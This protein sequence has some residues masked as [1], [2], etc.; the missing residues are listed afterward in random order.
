[1]R[2]TMTRPLFDWDAIEDSPSI[3]TLRLLLEAVPD[4]KLLRSL[5]DARGRGRDDYPVHVLWG[6]I[7]LTASLRHPSIQ[8]C[9]DELA[10]NAALRT[11][12]GIESE[13]GVPKKW[14]VSRF[15]RVLGREP[16]LTLLRETFNAM[17]N[18][19]AECVPEFG[20]RTAGDA[21]GLSARRSREK[22]PK[23]PKNSDADQRLPPPSG[24][25]KEYSDDEGRVTKIV[26]W[27]GYKLHL[28]VDVKHEVALAYQVTSTKDGDGETLP[29]LVEQA[30]AN[31]PPKRIQTLAYDKAADSNDV[32]KTLARADIKPLI[33]SRSLWKGE[34]ERTL[35]GHDGNSNVVYDETGTVYCYDRVSDPVV[36]HKMA[37]IGLEKSRGTLK[38]RCPAAHEGWRCR[39]E[40][41][42]N[43]GK[44]YGKT[45]RVK[46]E[47]DF[48]R[49]PPI[50]RA[51]KKFQRLYK[52]RTAVE[53]VN[54]RLKLFWG[55]DD[56]N[57]SGAERFFAFVGGVMIVHLAFATLLASQPRIDT[58]GKMRLSPIAERIQ[59]RLRA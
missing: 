44:P 22:T 6:V 36:R 31:L 8:A 12:I 20:K 5:D 57:I 58:L 7:L 2:V 3:R 50:P 56:G 25:R 49:F 9:L 19:L 23:V 42:C 41:R 27:F 53:R 16:H 30:E 54:A 21:T 55:A 17:V 48:R 39:S 51:T 11:L 4:S 15:L 1:M 13:D 38:Y 59:K 52:G 45:V 28:L 32:H 34:H 47:I 24:G 33:Q 43:A 40:S 46:Q 18:R 35:P 10:R 26:E 29:A 14:N 37:Y